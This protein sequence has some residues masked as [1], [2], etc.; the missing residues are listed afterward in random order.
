MMI[1]PTIPEKIAGQN[2]SEE[3]QCV[4]RLS[5]GRHKKKKQKKKTDKNN[6]S[7]L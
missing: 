5:W 1:D 7:P 2:N 6:M 3:K 4:A